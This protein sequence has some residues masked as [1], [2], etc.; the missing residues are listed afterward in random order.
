[1]SSSLK[2]LDKTYL[3]PND[4]NLSVGNSCDTQESRMNDGSDTSY[5]ITTYVK[6][7]V[8]TYSLSFNLSHVEHPDLIHELYKWE[9]LVGKSVNFTYCNIPFGRVMVNDFNV[10]FALDSITGVIGLSISFNLSDNI[11]LT[12]K[13][14]KV[15]EK[16]EVKEKIE[17]VFA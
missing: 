7:Q 5:A 4:C 12:N 3:L 14:K 6:P 10:S 2:Y 1:M 16:V 9:E 17:V 13:S 15:K 11:V 8:N